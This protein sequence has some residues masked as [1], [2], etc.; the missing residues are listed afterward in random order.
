MIKNNTVI[1]IITKP[2]YIFISDIHGNR[3]TIDLIKTARNDYPDYTLIGGGDYID[4]RKDSKAVLDYLM[5]QDNA[6]V[7]RGNHEQMLIDFVEGRDEP[8]NDDIGYME[9]LWFA[10]GGKTTLHSLFHYKFSN[11]K[12]KLA[13]Q[14]LKNSEYYQFL[15]QMPIM[16]DTPYIIFVHAGV[17]PI[18]NYDNPKNYKGIANYDYDMYR[19][20]ARSEYIYKC[21]NN[22]PVHQYTVDSKSHKEVS[23]PVFAH[24]KTGK[25]IVTGHTPTALISGIFDK[26]HKQ[27]RKKP[28]TH[29]DVLAIQYPNEPARIFTDNGNHSR[30]PNHD[31]NVVVMNNKGTIVNIYNNTHPN[32]VNH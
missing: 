32:G 20:W 15:K 7:L 24:N 18:A 13:Q 4:G 12:Y 23:L 29:C 25:A 21:S 3:K 5:T 6:V 11:S 10:N 28:F 14:M 17:L 1:D 22:I 16:Y 26:T 19:L 27:I 31:G 8:I 30:Y 2:G 9:P